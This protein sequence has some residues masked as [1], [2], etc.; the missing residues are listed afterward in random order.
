MDFFLKSRGQDQSVE[1]AVAV[2]FLA[3]PLLPVP[4]RTQLTPLSWQK[5]SNLLHELDA[6]LTS[7]ARST[8]VASERY[9]L[10]E[11]QQIIRRCILI[12]PPSYIDLLQ[13]EHE[14]WAQVVRAKMY[15]TLVL[16]RVHGDRLGDY[17][18]EI[19][20]GIKAVAESYNICLE[21]QDWTTVPRKQRH[22]NTVHT[23]QQRQEA[24]VEVEGYEEIL[25]GH[26]KFWYF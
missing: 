16:E 2:L 7:L 8:D 17:F 11:C 21:N 26:D 22:V 3:V 15:H 24:S 1:I 19:V 20:Q 13:M 14:I 18:E 4:Q 5:I 10:K 6:Y 12:D 25:F 23:G 9:N